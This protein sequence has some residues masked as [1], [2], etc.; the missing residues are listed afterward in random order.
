MIDY[1]NLKA[2]AVRKA[3]SKAAFNK[4]YRK[5]TRKQAM[6]LLEADYL[7]V[8]L[9]GQED[10]YGEIVD[11]VVTEYTPVTKIEFTSIED[12]IVISENSVGNVDSITISNI[13]SE[14]N[15][16]GDYT[17]PFK[18]IGT[19]VLMWVDGQLIVFDLRY[20]I[21]RLYRNVKP[22]VKMIVSMAVK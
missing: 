5:F 10:S 8:D 18:R 13:Y 14:F 12:D 7:R 1:I 4:K 19:D 9:I 17:V 6:L 16:G 21:H 11:I 2:A 20:R 15:I 22:K 3:S